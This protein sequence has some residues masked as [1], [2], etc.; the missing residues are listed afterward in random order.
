MNK[1]EFLGALRS[2]LSGQMHEGTMAAHVQYYRNYIDEQ[3]AKGRSEAEVLAELGDPRLIA[4]TLLDTNA[5]AS[6]SV[7]ESGQGYQGYGQDVQNYQ[8]YGESG[9]QTHVKKH[10]YKLDLSTWYGKLIVIIIAVVIIVGLVVLIGTI[11]PFLIVGAVI[12]YLI[13]KLKK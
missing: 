4:K 6:G 8:G 12:L 11:L 3:V 5:S 2:Q 1:E 9:Q 13:S 7:Y 10:S